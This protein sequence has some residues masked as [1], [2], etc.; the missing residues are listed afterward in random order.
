MLKQIKKIIYKKKFSSFFYEANKIVNDGKSVMCYLIED[1]KISFFYILLNEIIFII[2]EKEQP[3]IIKKFHIT[4]TL[5]QE[6]NFLNL[7]LHSQK[8]GEIIEPSEF[9]YFTFNFLKNIKEQFGINLFEQK[10]I[11]ETLFSQELFFN[12][13][14]SLI[15]PQEKYNWVD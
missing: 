8:N 12:S 2:K 11:F 1:K 3:I 13:N 6:L 4:Q 15:S 9:I 7:I 10:F 14:Q 5:N